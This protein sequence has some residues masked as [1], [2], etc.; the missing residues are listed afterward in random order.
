[1]KDYI[2][3][4]YLRALAALM[5]VAHHIFSTN[6]VDY[7]GKT[8]WLA[9]GVDI[10]F[11]ISGFIM[12]QST[13]GRDYAPAQ[14]YLR[15]IIR[16]VPIYWIA[17]LAVMWNTE[18]DWL[19][20]VKS[21]FFIPYVD[22]QTQSLMP[23][24]QPGWTLNYEMFFYLIFGMSLL[25]REKI[26]VFAVAA[27]LMMLVLVGI[28]FQPAG[29][30]GFYTHPILLEFLLGML[31]AR[32][33]IKLPILFAPIALLAIP[34]LWDAVEFRSL[35]L[36]LPAAI[37]VASLLS[38]ERQIPK[39]PFLMRLGDASYSIYLFHLGALGLVAAVA[40]SYPMSPVLVL[41]A[42]LIMAALVGLS[43][44]HYLEMPINNVLK[45]WSRHQAESRSKTQSVPNG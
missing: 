7:D 37:I 15:R 36:G 33:G 22:P 40:G 34:H 38:V 26:R 23:I 1:M 2:S 43:I 18:W 14:F 10:F 29:A 11:V 5:V 12:V 4:Q 24:L 30:S 21:L 20:A 32:F 25:L 31:I 27:C 42:G 19:N 17:T 28:V 6:L 44:H 16:I 41:F 3:I 8:G 9:G 35:T 39:V 13:G 45:T